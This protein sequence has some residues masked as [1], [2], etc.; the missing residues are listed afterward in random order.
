MSVYSER[1]QRK[2]TEKSEIV[3]YM[4]RKVTKRKTG[5]GAVRRKE[6]E[7]KV[8]SDDFAAVDVREE[9]CHHSLTETA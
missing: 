4:Q 7:M 1:S 9:L 6:G 2:S 8:F 5:Q 3:A